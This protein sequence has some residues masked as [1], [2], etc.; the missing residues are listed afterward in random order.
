VTGKDGTLVTIGIKSARVYPIFSAGNL[1]ATLK[2]GKLA[3]D[4]SEE[5]RPDPLR[6]ARMACKGQAWGWVVCLAVFAAGADQPSR[7]PDPK[8][9]PPPVLVQQPDSPSPRPSV[10]DRPLESPP[11][12]AEPQTPAAPDPLFQ[13]D[14]DPPLGFT[15]PS[16][17]RP[18][19]S[20]QSSHFVPVEDRWR[21]GFLEWDRYGK[22]HPPVDDYPYVEGR[23]YDPFN[24]NVLKGDYPI[25]GQ[26]TFLNLTGTLLTVVEGRQLPTPA[27]GFDST[28]RPFEEEAFGRP[29]Q[30]FTTNFLSLSVDLS[31]GDA[32]FKPTDWRIRL[33]PV[34]NVNYVD[35]EEVGIVSPNVLKGTDRGRTWFALQEW[36]AETK[37]ADLS[38][39]YDFVSLRAGS[40]FFVS[41]FRGFLFDETNRGVRLFGNYEANHDQYNL[42]YFRQLEKDT[43]SDL[44]T[45]EE[46]HQDVLIG[47]YYRQDFIFPGYTAQVS[48]HYNHDEPSFHFDK[49]GFLVRP[50]PVGVFHEHE[51]NVVYLGWAGDGHIG[52]INITHQVYWALGHDSLNP[53]ANQPQDINAQMAAVELSYNRDW[54]RFRTSFLWASGDEDINNSHAT[55]F[56]TILDH[57]N[58]AGG[59]FSFW[60][61]QQ[62]KLLG[63]NLVNRESLVPDL[64]S[65]KTEGQSNFVNPG[66][67]LFNVG[68]DMDLTPK[69]K[70]VNNAN[71][72]WFD[73]TQVLEQFIF[74]GTV[75]HFIGTDL[76]TGVEYRPLLSNNVIVKC[77]L[78]TLL[79][80]E[81]F[82]DIY[83]T[84]NGPTHSLFAGFMELNLTF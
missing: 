66:L 73:E 11:T 36:F 23:W 76:S 53:L 64:R 43:N 5:E 16:G 71:L 40:Q 60:Q 74:Q 20:Q 45:F 59:D 48:V 1:V 14:V 50:D 68:V 27:N 22:G 61:R 15:G 35:V 32:A 78:A 19:D 4:H 84:L 26:H 49:N 24:L 69:W 65:S 10:L 34:F 83:S 17:I 44:N 62:I 9:L 18:R 77:G 13:Y 75:H 82:K 70:L 51:L 37:L 12:P 42:V 79:P 38:P 55:G 56:D 28:A 67:L 57:P 25:I 6:L 47:N 3:A 31:H 63:V 33:T 21:I 46:R 29:D 8:T 7:L 58:F 41:D 72:L 39:D 54:V 2:S 30:F 80:G 52:R 81:G